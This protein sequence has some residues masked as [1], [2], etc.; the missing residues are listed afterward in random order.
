LATEL[1]PAAT[2]PPPTP[3]PGGGL[4][5]CGAE[6]VHLAEALY[7]HF[8]QFVLTVLLVGCGLA[9]TLGSQNTAGPPGP[10]TIAL[11][12]LGAA[13]SIVGLAR[14]GAVYRWLR[15]NRLHQI[16]PAAIAVIALTINGPDSATWW[17]ALPLLWIVAVVSSTRLTLAASLVTSV[18][19]LA[20]TLL[21]GESLIPQGSSGILAAAIGLLVNAMAGRYASEA[22]ARYVLRLHRLEQQIS[23]TDQ[24]LRVPNLATQTPPKYRRPGTTLAPRAPLS[25][26]ADPVR[27]ALRLTARQLEV[28]LLTCDG[29]RQAEIA[30]CL[31]ISP[32]QVE[33][34]IGEARERAQAQTTSHLV[35]ML[36]H[37]RIAP[38]PAK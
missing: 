32:R 12:A 38:A 28:A 10:L 23:T 1:Q 37:A 3:P 9:V 33:R 36:I 11:A 25:T 20:G 22:F 35:A 29:L 21:G 34:L 16:A 18:G 30:V 7:V 26:E 13:F 15:Y 17:E 4:I 27:G 19:Y 5:R 31:A 6:L 8:L 2:A 14:T 24:P